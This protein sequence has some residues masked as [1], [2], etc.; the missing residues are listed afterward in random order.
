MD[1][2]DKVDKV[3][4]GAKEFYE[5]TLQSFEKVVLENA[6]DAVEHLVDEGKDETVIAMAAALS[7]TNSMEQTAESF[8][9]DEVAE[10]TRNLMVVLIAKLIKE[11]LR[12]KKRLARVEN[13]KKERND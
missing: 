6:I 4:K 10:A 5:D 1:E 7:V 12:K 13:L 9:D 11:K 3:D 8:S 2:V